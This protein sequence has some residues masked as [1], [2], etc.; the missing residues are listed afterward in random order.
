VTSIGDKPLQKTIAGTGISD[1]TG[2]IAYPRLVTAQLT[3]HLK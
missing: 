1:L 3:Y 2:Q